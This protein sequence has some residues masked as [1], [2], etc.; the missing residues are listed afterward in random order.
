MKYDLT[1]YND[2]MLVQCFVHFYSYDV[3]YLFVQLCRQHLYVYTNVQP[4]PQYVIFLDDIMGLQTINAGSN[5][6]IH[7]NCTHKRS[8]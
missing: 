5:Q 2:E 7:F 4:H 3:S 1:T 8:V 6:T